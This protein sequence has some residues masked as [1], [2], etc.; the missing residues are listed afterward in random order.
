VNENGDACQ[1]LHA[2]KRPN[3][4]G[5]TPCQNHCGVRGGLCCPFT[6]AFEL[7]DPFVSP[8]GRSGKSLSRQ[9]LAFC[10]IEQPN[11]FRWNAQSS[12]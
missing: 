2:V 4:T 10:C 11:S 6:G 7:V 12:H 3:R 1:N 5:R 9:V 8:K